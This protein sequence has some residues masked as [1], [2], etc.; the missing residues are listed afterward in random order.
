MNLKKSNSDYF[1]PMRSKR[2][3][4]IGLV[5]LLTCFLFACGTT[6]Y[7]PKENIGISKGD[8]SEMIKGRSAYIK[9]CGNCHALV[10]PEKHSAGEWKVWVEK[11]SLKVDLTATEQAEILKYLTKNDSSALSMKTNKA[12]K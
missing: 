12:R 7:L 11:M 5:I 4:R 9:K 1:F 3:K 10:L 8:L 2:R 6:L